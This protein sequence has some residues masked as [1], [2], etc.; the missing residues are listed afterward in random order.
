MA[1]KTLGNITISYNSNALQS[2]LSQASVEAI[3]SEL[4]ITNLASSATEK[5][6]GLG[7][8]TVPVSG[9]WS[10]TLD[11]YL[12]PDSI[13]PPASL[14]TLVVVVGVSGST[15]TLTWTS[16]AFI[17]NYRVNADSPNAPITWSGTLSVSGNPVRS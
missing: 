10:P 9:F 7:N 1:V 14:R 15:V 6:P 13:T 8:W 16:N 2:H 11:G 5:I 3:I 17:S 4:D 12:A